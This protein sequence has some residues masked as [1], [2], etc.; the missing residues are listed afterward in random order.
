MM[1]TTGQSRSMTITFRSMINNS[2]FSASF[3]QRHTAHSADLM[4]FFNKSEAGKKSKSSLSDVACTTNFLYAPLWLQWG[5][6]TLS[7]CDDSINVIVEWFSGPLKDDWLH[8]IITMFNSSS[9][10][11]K[12]L[13]HLMLLFFRCVY[14][15]T[16]TCSADD[17]KHNSRTHT[18]G[19]FPQRRGSF[20]E[21]FTTIN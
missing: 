7:R 1:E 11:F 9:L 6:N 20:G 5:R 18:A 14:H 13:F 12:F 8:H 2:S 15:R 16:Q 19:I 17:K 21:T 10:S 3:Q 4:Y